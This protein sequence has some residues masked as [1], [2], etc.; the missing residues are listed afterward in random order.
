[1]GTSFGCHDDVGAPYQQ[2]VVNPACIFVGMVNAADHALRSR[3]SSRGFTPIALSAKTSYH[4]SAF[5]GS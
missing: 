4:D 1:M 5:I 2:C 3:E